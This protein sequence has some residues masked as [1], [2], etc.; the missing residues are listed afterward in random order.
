[1]LAFVSSPTTMPRFLFGSSEATALNRARLTDVI[2]GLHSILVNP[3]SKLDELK[4]AK[5]RML[6]VLDETTNFPLPHL[7]VAAS[8]LRPES[9]EEGIASFELPDDTTKR[10]VAP[11]FARSWT[12]F[13]EKA[14]ASSSRSFRAKPSDTRSR[15][16]SSRPASEISQSLNYEQN[17]PNHTHDYV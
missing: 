12:T 8:T 2:W 10:P 9:G 14:R 15:S 7:V 6:R 3:V 17:S 4:N 1:M 13:T 11:A 5:R 16:A